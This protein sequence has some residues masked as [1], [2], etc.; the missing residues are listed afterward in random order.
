MRLVVR[1]HRHTLLTAEPL[2]HDFLLAEFTLPA[3]A[4]WEV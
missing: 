1:Q 3:Q 2:V 4:P